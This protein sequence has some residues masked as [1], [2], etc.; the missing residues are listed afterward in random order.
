MVRSNSQSPKE[1]EI[2]MTFIYLMNFQLD[3]TA[4]SN[5]KK[6]LK[7]FLRQKSAIMAV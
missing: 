2:F 5:L 1:A 6:L 3:M 7:M 4:E